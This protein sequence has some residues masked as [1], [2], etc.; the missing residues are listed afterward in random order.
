MLLVFCCGSAVRCGVGFDFNQCGWAV[1]CQVGDVCSVYVCIAFEAKS[2]TCIA[3]LW[4]YPNVL[5]D[6]GKALN[7][8]DVMLGG[9]KSIG[10]GLKASSRNGRRRRYTRDIGSKT[11]R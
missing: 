10:A 8:I 7:D 11:S 2:C 6:Y 3:S 5:L 4:I 9:S 1:S